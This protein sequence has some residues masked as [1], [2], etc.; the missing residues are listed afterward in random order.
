MSDFRATARA[1]APFIS[2]SFSLLD[3]VDAVLDVVPLEPISPAA[4]GKS[5]EWKHDTLLRLAQQTPEVIAELREGRKIY[6]IKAL[7]TVSLC[8]LKDAKDVIEDSRLRY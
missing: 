8:G 1:L 3:A 6:A 5:A 2:D 4:P 7:R